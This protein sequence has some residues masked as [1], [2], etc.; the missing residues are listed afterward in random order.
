MAEEL[1]ELIEKI[2]QEGVQVAEDKARDI[3][4]EAKRRAEAVTSQAKKD[5][6]ALIAQAKE[7][8]AR[9]EESQKSSLQQTARD[10]LISLKKEI[11]AVL[12][13]L[14]VLRVREALRPDELAKIITSLIKDYKGGRKEDIIISLKKE[15]LEKLEKGLLSDLSDETKKG[16]TLKPSEDVIGGFTI[17]FDGGKSQFD[18]TDKALAEYIGSCLK[19]KLGEILSGADSTKKKK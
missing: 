16:I 8:I 18:F 4:G 2:H 13:K 1:K 17:S 11:S 5:A 7:K 12:D 10:L 14:V 19:P 15:D 9:M 3:E 6:E